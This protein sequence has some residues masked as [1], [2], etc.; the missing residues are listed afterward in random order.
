MEDTEDVIYRIFAEI[1]QYPLEELIWKMLDFL[2]SEYNLYSELQIDR[3]SH[4]F[5]DV[6][7][8]LY[9]RQVLK[10]DM[11]LATLLITLVTLYNMVHAIQFPPRLK[12]RR[13]SAP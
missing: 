4:G 3:S 11:K 9:Q 5:H 2:D 10:H 7:D 13:S 6:M 12:N 1:K 8:V